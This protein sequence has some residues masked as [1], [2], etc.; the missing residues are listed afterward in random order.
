LGGK[1]PVFVFAD[2][3]LE[4]AIPAVA[5]GI[6][7]NAGQGCSAG[8]RLYAHRSVFDRVLEGVEA[9]A[10][11]LRVGPGLDPASQIGPVISETQL[12]RVMGYIASGRRDGASVAVGGSRVGN[13]GYFIEPT[14]LTGTTADMAVRR[15]E[16]F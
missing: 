2:A 14:V 10:R 5:N 1:S 16:I 12:E 6:F 15:E 3:D 11:K 7:S 9:H 4:R 8:S 13:E